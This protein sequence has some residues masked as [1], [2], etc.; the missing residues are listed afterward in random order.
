[1]LGLFVLIGLCLV[2]LPAT[3]QTN[4]E[5]RRETREL[6]QQLQEMQKRMQ[7]L[8]Q[9]LQENEQKLEETEKEQKWNTED[10]EAMQE[11]L[12]KAERHAAADKV[13]LSISLEPRLWSIH[14]QDTRTAFPVLQEA[15]PRL[16]VL[17]SARGGFSASEIQQLLKG[18]FPLSALQASPPNGFGFSPDVARQLADL[19]NPPEVDVDNHAIRTLRFRLRMDAELNENL[20]FAGRLAAY[21]VFGDSTGI[22]FNKSGF[23]D[24]SFD[25]TTA[26]NP[27]GNT[28]RLERA[29][30]I[31]SNQFGPVPW[32]FSLGRRPS[33]EGPPLQYKNNLPVVGGSPHAHTINW[34]FD[35]GSL[36]FN[37]EEVVGIP[38]FD[39]KLCYGSGFENQYGTSSAFLSEPST[40]DVD[41][42][43]AI[44]TLYESYIPQADTDLH[45]S[46]NVA[47]APNITDGFTGLTVFPF[48][49]TKNRNGNFEFLTNDFGAVSRFEPQSKIGDWYA[50]DLLTEATVLEGNLNLFLSG[51]W[52]HTDAEKVSE[53]PLFEM[54]GMSLLSSEGELEE[55]DGWSVYTGGRYTVQDWGTKLGL[56]YNYG[57]KYWFNVTGAEDNLVGSKLST[58]GHVLEPYV[59]QQVIGDNFFFRV[60]AQLYWFNYS[61]SGFPLGAPVDVDEVT[62]LDTIFPVIDTMQ[63][64]YLSVVA[65]F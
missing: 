61:G 56:E 12:T 50:V 9:E 41:F 40:D 2:A 16:E 37:L 47:F 38:G 19:E 15:F 49:V 22:N 20:R 26:S 31:Y 36:N 29:Y 59:I 55:H 46:Y 28:I 44:G 1:L 45:V 42:F 17:Q 35:G 11:R 51:A 27:H 53:I 65:R 5:I 32:S 39:F 13:E 63:Q 24:I 23:Q 18:E 7:K 64:Y 3:A 10:I 30:F 34:E 4:E 8:Q 43:G 54:L 33:T 58:R 48:T 62:G 14:M 21:K 60:G 52:S 25:G 57:S 6:Q